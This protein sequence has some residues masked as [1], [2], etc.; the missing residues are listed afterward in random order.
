MIGQR[1]LVCGSGMRGNVYK[2][3]LRAKGQKVNVTRSRDKIAQKRRIYPVNVTWYR[4]FIRLIGN[5]DCR[6]EWQGQI[7][8]RKL[9]YRCFAHAQW[10]NAQ[11]SLILLSNCHNF[12][13]FI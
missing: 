2:T 6:S 12:I 1:K 8:D 11:N 5:R 9:L 7:F 4:K 13:L 10:K 3:M